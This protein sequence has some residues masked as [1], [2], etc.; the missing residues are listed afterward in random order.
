MF[1]TPL[2]KFVKSGIFNVLLSLEYLVKKLKIKF[3]KGTHNYLTI[4]TIIR[5]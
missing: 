5:S 2:S 1:I 4:W 3:P